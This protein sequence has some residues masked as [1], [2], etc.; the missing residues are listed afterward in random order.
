LDSVLG[1]SAGLKHFG[2][3]RLGRSG[4]ADPLNV[5]DNVFEFDVT[6]YIDPSNGAHSAVFAAPPALAIVANIL[7]GIDRNYIA[8]GIAPFAATVTAAAVPAAR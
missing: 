7:R 2:T 3:R 5:W 8:R 4:L 1:A 6:T